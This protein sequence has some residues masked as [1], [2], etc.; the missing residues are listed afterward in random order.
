MLQICHVSYAL[1]AHYK[2]VFFGTPSSDLQAV[3]VNVFSYLQF[4]ELPVLI[5]SEF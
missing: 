2:A 3:F 1:R 5:I 4:S